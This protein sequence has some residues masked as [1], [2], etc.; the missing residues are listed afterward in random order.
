MNDAIKHRSRHSS[1]Y[2]DNLVSLERVIQ[3]VKP[4][5]VMYY[6]KILEENRAM[7]IMLPMQSSIL[8]LI[9]VSKRKRSTKYFKNR[10]RFLCLY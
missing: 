1:T 9:S 8:K 5:S 6:Q 3:D 10:L 4:T 2:T 7:R